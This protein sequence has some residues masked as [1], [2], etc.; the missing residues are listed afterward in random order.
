MKEG[1]SLT[2][3]GRYFQTLPPKKQRD[4][5]RFIKWVDEAFTVFGF[6]KSYLN[7]RRSLQ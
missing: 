6:D 2:G 1:K 7:I 3:N 5:Q 4:E